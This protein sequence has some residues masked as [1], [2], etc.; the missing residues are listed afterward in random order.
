MNN[1]M[2]RILAC[3]LSS[4]CLL[5]N[6]PIYAMSNENLSVVLDNALSEQKMNNLD[7]FS[8]TDFIKGY[9]RLYG[10]SFLS[11][12]SENP[13]V[14]VS[15]HKNWS[16]QNLV[17]KINAKDNAGIRSIT[18]YTDEVGENAQSGNHTVNVDTD[19]PN[20]SITNETELLEAIEAASN[21]SSESST[22]VLEN[23]ISVE[24]VLNIPNGVTLNVNSDVT[25]TL[26]GGLSNDGTLENEGTLFIGSEQ[27]LLSGSNS[28]DNMGRLLNNGD[29][30]INSA[31][32][33]NGDLDN[34]G[35]IYIGNI[36]L[37]DLEVPS[38]CDYK[39]TSVENNT[40]H[41]QVMGT[42]DSFSSQDWGLNA[43][44]PP[45]FSEFVLSNLNIGGSFV[46][47]KQYNEAFSYYYDNINDGTLNS[48]EN[49][50]VKAYSSPYSLYLLADGSGNVDNKSISVDLYYAGS[51]GTFTLDEVNRILGYVI[52]YS[53]LSINAPIIEEESIP[54]EE[55]VPAEDI[56]PEEDL[57]NGETEILPEED[58][59][60]GET[61]ILPEEDLGNDE[62]ETLPEEDLENGETEILPEEDLGNDETETL[63][64]EDL[65]NDETETLPEGDLENGEGETLPEEDLGFTEDEGK[66]DNNVS[67]DSDTVESDIGDST[68]INNLPSINVLNRLSGEQSSNSDEVLFD[69]TMVNE[70]DYTLTIE[71]MDISGNITTVTREVHIDKTAPILDEI[72]VQ[73]AKSDKILTDNF[74]SKDGLIFTISSSD[75]LSG[76]SSTEYRMGSGEWKK[77]ENNTLKLVDEYNGDIY[78]RSI[79]NAGNVSEE[80]QISV[81]I[82]RTGPILN[83]S[84]TESWSNGSPAFTF[85]VEDLSFP[86]RIDW[87]SKNSSDKTLEVGTFETT[88]GKTN[89]LNLR[90][91]GEYDVIIRATDSVG[92]YKTWSVPVKVEKASDVKTPVL[93]TN[94]YKE[95]TLSDKDITIDLKCPTTP[96]SGLKYF[97][98]SLDDGDTWEETDGEF[99]IE[100]EEPFNG[101]VIFRT[102]SKAGNKS[103]ATEPFE[104]KMSEMF[105]VTFNTNGGNKLSKLE[106]KS[107]SVLTNLPTPTRSGYK[108]NG[109][110]L[111]SNLTSKLATNYKVTKNIILYASWTKLQTGFKTDGIDIKGENY[112][113]ND[114][115]SVS[116]SITKGYIYG[117]PNNQFA[118]KDNLTR[119]EFATIIDRVF[120][121]KNSSLKSGF[122]DTV[123][124]WAEDSIIM[125]YSSGVITGVGNN[126]FA[127]DNPIT[128]EEVLL[129][130]GRIVNVDNY[131]KENALVSRTN[132]N[133]TLLS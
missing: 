106:V 35:S 54:L 128:M 129:I 27:V 75:T 23:S 131:S 81:S 61:E 41:Y 82:D 114:G 116:S 123:N 5:S 105:T 104:I 34:N 63:P 17:F 109:W 38:G 89:N 85:R 60:N 78:F 80:S 48:A 95:G 101:E 126:Q 26:L 29:L 55:L 3:L 13:I 15:E 84:N 73:D 83:V 98:Y 62:T 76:V 58:L 127:P 16:N 70:G 11:L 6:V 8:Y 69:I 37:S 59:E 2:K 108:F 51:A 47:I 19:E 119:A 110:Y 24:S 52:D 53:S 28:F 31:F 107:N 36:L 103:V 111:D 121:F 93:D 68:L 74:A 4:G 100:K 132:T 65:G 120:D 45:H 50:K 115:I 99:Y 9:N 49:L 32:Y 125:L 102:V 46:G 94:G 133:Y 66:L 39:L 22:V 56:L 91:S 10:A 12:D 113:L 124:H 130:L 40:V 67:N 30:Y 71:V 21:G 112:Y 72:I 14:S 25:L 122:S 1:D 20:S 88:S 97:E 90:Y 42:T 64:E 79:D 118:G 87:S 44:V 18:W 92:N 7:M 57:E 43:D 77:I 96:P 33:N 86:I 117:R